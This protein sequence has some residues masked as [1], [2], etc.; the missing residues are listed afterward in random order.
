ML[1]WQKLRPRIIV[2]DNASAPDDLRQLSQCQHPALKLICNTSNQGFAGG[3]NRGMEWAL[4]EN[5]TRPILLMNNDAQIDE[6][7]LIALLDSLNANPN[8][9]MLGPLLYAPGLPEVLISAG[10]KDPMWHIHTLDKSLTEHDHVT[11]NPCKTVDYISGSV[12]LLRAEAVQQVGLLDE[13]YFFNTEIADWCARARILDWQTGV[14]LGLKAYHN[15]HRSSALRS[16]LY[17]YYVIRNRVY[18]VAK[19]ANG[20]RWPLTAFWTGYSMALAAKLRL[21]GHIPQAQAVWMGALDGLQQRLGGQNER[22][23]AACQPKAGANL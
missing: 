17:T 2:V 8:I 14:H 20:W 13:A 12:A 16:T 7:T 4:R 19:H 3:S 6:A 21:A 23:L 11:P 22:V 9:G 1:Q 15:L 5:P 10:S 18:Y